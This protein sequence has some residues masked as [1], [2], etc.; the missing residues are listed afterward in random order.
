MFDLAV[1]PFALLSGVH[2]TLFGI[3]GSSGIIAVILIIVLV[4]YVIGTTVAF[5]IIKKNGKEKNLYKPD[6]KGRFLPVYGFLKIKSLPFVFIPIFKRL[7]M[8]FLIGI[9]YGNPTGQ[10]IA[11]G[12]ISILYPVLVLVTDS[13]ADPLQAWAESIMSVLTAICYFLLF[14]F[15][16]TT[17]PL[18]Q[19]SSSATGG[20][21]AIAAIYISLHYLAIGVAL[22]LYI[23]NSL[24]LMQVFTLSQF[25]ACLCGKKSNE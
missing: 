3:S 18:D 16:S 25:K 6:V 15:S 1:F 8:G 11:G 4:L 17:L 12:I 13:Y 7:L 20:Y 14:G 9:L 19:Q 22:C 2:L 23:V 21:T 10:I 24:Q 5:I